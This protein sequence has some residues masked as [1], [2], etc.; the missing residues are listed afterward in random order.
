MRMNGKS[1]GFVTA[2]VVAGVAFVIGVLA[3]NEKHRKTL[4]KHGKNITTQIKKVVKNG[5]SNLTA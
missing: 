4:V 3:T 5:K 2:L 1:K